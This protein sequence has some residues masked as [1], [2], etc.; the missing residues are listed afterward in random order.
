MCWP[1]PTPRSFLV[2]DR[3]LNLVGY[4]EHPAATQSVNAGALRQFPIP[5]CLLPRLAVDKAWQG[6]AS[7]A[8]YSATC[9]GGA[10]A[11]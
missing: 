6:P 11:G 2:T 8:I 4:L 10:W 5:I 3:Q 9:S 7:A 1:V